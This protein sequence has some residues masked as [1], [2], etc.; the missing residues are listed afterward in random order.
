MTDL[1]PRPLTS[2]C[3]A[4]TPVTGSL[5]VTVNA[6]NVSTV[7]PGT[8]SMRSTVGATESFWMASSEASKPKSLL[9]RLLWK[10]WTARTLVPVCR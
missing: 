1:A 5:K 8:G 7:E 2:R 3:A 6:V 10:T 9:P 4:T